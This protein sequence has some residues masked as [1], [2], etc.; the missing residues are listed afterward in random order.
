MKIFNKLFKSKNK[1]V[2]IYSPLAG[3]VIDITE[4]P[5]PVFAEK[6]VGDGFAVI[7]KNG[8]V[9]APLKG[10]IK[11][12]FST[13]HAIAIESSEGLEILIHIGLETVEL[14]GEGFELKVSSGAFIEVGEELLN[15]DI[16]FLEKNNK[17]II[18]P[19]VITNYQE[20]IK[21]ITKV[22]NAEISCGDLILECELK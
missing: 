2:K 7:P 17:E 22:S 3:E 6:M 20:K 9:V 18:S 16:D 12:I 19:I 13:K 5:D 10:K 1:I 14:E 11:E 8:K 4:V 15:F 21:K